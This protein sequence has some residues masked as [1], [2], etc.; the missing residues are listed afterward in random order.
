MPLF[1]AVLLLA[2]VPLQRPSDIVKWSAV[3]QAG[4]GDAVTVTVTAKVQAGWKL[5]AIEQP[6]GGPI[7]LAFDLADGAPYDIVPGQIVSPKAKVQKQDANFTVDTR[8]YEGEAKFTV[9]VRMKGTVP[10]GARTIPLEITF[11][12]CG[13]ELCLR[14]FTERLA[15]P[16]T[17][18]R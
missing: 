6:P 3:A 12:A 14:P 13:A 4:S 16:V 15:V 17:V 5:Y 18:R 2:L 7:P 1:V 9:P 10:A 11:Q 8:Y